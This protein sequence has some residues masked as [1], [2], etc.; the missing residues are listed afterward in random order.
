MSII[1]I[2][3]FLNILF[4]I[5][6]QIV[7]VWEE[8]VWIGW[9]LLSLGLIFVI[10]SVLTLRSKGTCG[11]INTGIYS[12]LRHPMY[13]GV[14]LAVLC[15]PLALGSLWALIPALLIVFL[16]VVRTGLEDRTLMEE[17]PGYKLYAERVCFRLIPGIW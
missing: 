5:F 17:L 9:G 15:V 13:V 11:V 7:P 4:L 10:L 3:F 12:I 8:L 16:F 14:I 1:A 2:I 6:T